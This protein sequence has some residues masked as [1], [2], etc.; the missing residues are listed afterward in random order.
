MHFVGLMSGTSMDGVDAVLARMEAGRPSLLAHVCIPYPDLLRTE[1]LALN[2]PG[3]DEIH[4]AALAANAI[5]DLYAQ[6]VA[7]VLAEGGMRGEH[8]AAL[9]AHG[10]TV[11][12]RPDLGYT[13]QLLD[14]ARL[15]ERSGIATVCDFRSRDVAAGGQGAPLVPA[16]HAAVFGD[17]ARRQI[18]LHLGGIANVTVLKPGGNAVTGF[19]TGPA[20]AL[21]D[22]W[23]ERQTGQ[24]FDPDGAYAESGAPIPAMLDAMLA[25]PFFSAP[26]PKSTGRDLISWA[27]LTRFEP[28]DHRPQDVQ[29]TLLALTVQTIA[30]NIRDHA[31]LPDEV[32]VCGGGVLNG[33]LMRALQAALFPA[34]VASSAAYGIDPLCVEALA[35][36][37]LAWRHVEGLAGNLA[38]VTGARGARV[39]GALHP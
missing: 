11:R 22:L 13:V 25:E 36:A 12:H 14:G 21:L 7:A 29:A 19:D 35:F 5:A 1:C 30:K 8:I 37:W 20:N 34:R 31:G 27:W 39:L 38:E 4:R 6:A 2:I 10:Q 26:P 17:P 15:A 33:A 9:G 16:F 3:P 23:F 24:R 32:L 28:E 18:I